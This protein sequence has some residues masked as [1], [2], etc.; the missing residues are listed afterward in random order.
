MWFTRLPFWD[1]VGPAF[2]MGQLLIVVGLACIAMGLWA[3][4][5]DTIVAG[6]LALVPGAFGWFLLWRT[7]ADDGYRPRRR[8][9]RRVTKRN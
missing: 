9:E 5:A 4:K 7:Y 3:D 1:R 8:N 6:L 2:V